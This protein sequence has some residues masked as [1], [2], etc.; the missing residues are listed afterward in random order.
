MRMENHPIFR[1]VE[2]TIETHRMLR[3]GDAVLIGVSGGPDSVALLHVL[4]AVGRN[5]RLQLG[6]IH[7]NHGLRGADSDRD[8]NFVKSLCRGFNLSFFEKKS[9]IASFRQ[10]QK[11]S[12]EE[13]SRRVRYDFFT[14][15]AD[16]HGYNKVALGHHIDDVAELLL[17]NILRGSGPQGLSGIP[18]V[19]EGRFIRPLIDLTKDQ[20]KRFLDDADIP[21]VV[22]ASNQD[23]RHRRNRIRHQLIPLLRKE[24]NPDISK[25]LSR[26]AGILREETE[27]IDRLTE[28]RFRECILSESE[29]RLAFSVARLILLER[30]LV[31][32]I[33]RMGVCRVKG[34]L[35]R[36]RFSHIEA[37][38]DMTAEAAHGSSAEKQLH[39]PDRILIRRTADQ[40]IIRK[41]KIPHR[42]ASRAAPRPLAFS[43]WVPRP[44]R[45]LEI[46]IPEI[47]GRM[48]FTPL[49]A[50]AFPSVAASPTTAF[51]DID[52]LTFPLLLRSFQPG[53]RFMPLGMDGVQK[54]KDL[55]INQKIPQSERARCP[56]LVSAGKIL[57]IAGYRTA[58]FAK[59]SDSSQ[60]LLKVEFFLPNFP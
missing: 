16:G 50:D 23:L 18:P 36:I 1:I 4:L 33:L 13:A 58:E 9:D 27:W 45:Q 53:D 14:Q 29:D 60:K 2:K 31:R 32:R 26:L 35:R 54:L 25:T 47:N 49:W 51:F 15:I 38:L 6:V 43:H 11:L 7:L 42:G 30:P 48:R 22:D 56:L 12:L 19:R 52:V 10:N 24:Y 28:P 40:I 3:A 46:L 57:W 44:Y 34:N 5:M 55:F 8:A 37:V 21:H 59:V 20:I 41:A 17:M 39:L